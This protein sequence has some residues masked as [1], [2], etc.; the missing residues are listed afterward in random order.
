MATRD[1]RVVSR[2]AAAQAVDARDSIAKAI[3]SRLFSHILSRINDSIYKWV[4]RTNNYYYYYYY[5][6]HLQKWI[7]IIS[8]KEQEL[9]KLSKDTNFHINLFLIATIPRSFRPNS[10]GLKRT[11]IGILDIFGFENFE[12]NSFEQL[13]INYANEHLQQFFVQHIFKMEQKEYDEVGSFLK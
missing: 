13:C 1:E 6:A 12:N 7:S 9:P 3:Y 11:S 10:N 2:L 8:E 4:K 5:D